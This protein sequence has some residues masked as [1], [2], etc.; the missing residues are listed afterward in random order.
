MDDRQRS[1]VD[2]LGYQLAVR[3][4]DSA[5]EAC[6]QLPAADQQLLLKDVAK[7][8]AERLSA[9]QPEEQ[10]AVEDKNSR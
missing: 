8:V 2:E 6:K 5:F 3:Y 9:A 10:K 7:R 1:I 4:F